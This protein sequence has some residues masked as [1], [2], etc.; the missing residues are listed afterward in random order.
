[1]TTTPGRARRPC[2]AQEVA[3]AV[4]DHDAIGVAVERDADV[5]A[6]FADLRGE[7][8]GGGRAHVAVDVEAVRIDPH[9]ED[10]G[11][12]F[13]KRLRRDAV[14]GAVGAIDDDADAVERQGP[15]QGALGIFDVAVR[16]ALDPLGASEIGGGG[17]ASGEVG[18]DQGFDRGL[19]GVGQLGPVRTEQLDAVI[20]IGVVRGRNHHAE[21]APHR[22]GEH[23]DARSRNRPGQ[24][25]VD[26]NS[27]EA[28]GQRVLDHV[29]RQPGVLAD[30]HAVA[31]VAVGEDEAGRHADLHGDVRRD[32][33]PVGAAANA[34]GPEILDAHR[35]PHACPPRSLLSA[36]FAIPR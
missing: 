6:H 32:R 19:V 1:V 14:A 5:G 22:P 27:E 33:R 4:D 23:R 21:V 31:M 18:I 30:H 36:I 15:G 12:E 34:I 26:A 2:S 35:Y 16:D 28:G 20:V 8:G 3:I 11:A 24:Q 29:A 7:R 13:P 17:K 25:H 10:L 9:R